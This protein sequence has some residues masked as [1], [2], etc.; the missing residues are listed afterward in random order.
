MTSPLRIS[1]SPIV[2]FNLVAS[3]FF[4][5]V[6][7]ISAVLFD[8]VFRVVIVVVSLALFAVGVAGFLVGFFAAVQRSRE[9][10]ISVSQLFFLTGE[11]APRDV[12]VPMLVALLLQTAAGIAAAIARPTTDGKTGSV[13]AFGVLVPM[14]GLGLNGLWA[15]RHGTFVERARPG[16]TDDAGPDSAE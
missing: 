2:R 13:L 1:T 15:S 7:I 3:V 5:V 14:L 9:R 4:A 10:E 6:A 16:Q 8:D 12:R 11:V